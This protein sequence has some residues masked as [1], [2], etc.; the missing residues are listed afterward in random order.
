MEMFSGSYNRINLIMM[1]VYS[2]HFFFDPCVVFVY[3]TL[4]EFSECC[5]AFQE[6]PVDRRRKRRR[7]NKW[8][9]EFNLLTP[10]QGDHIPLF[11]LFN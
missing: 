10:Y 11:D 8:K 2:E 5:V 1:Y 3:S 6:E 7:K 9:M 4:V